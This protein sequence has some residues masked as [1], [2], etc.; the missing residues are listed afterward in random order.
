MI[1]SPTLRLL[2]NSFSF[3]I[4]VCCGLIIKKYIAAKIRIIGKN[5]CISPIS[6]IQLR[7]LSP[8]EFH[9]LPRY[10]LSMLHFYFANLLKSQRT[11]LSFLQFHLVESELLVFQ[12][13]YTLNLHLR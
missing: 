9:F 11:L 12:E 10:S 5:C 4:L 2:S 6:T 1:L 8:S 13:S 3:L 7:L